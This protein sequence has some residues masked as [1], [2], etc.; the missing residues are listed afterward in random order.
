MS[1]QT[2]PTSPTGPPTSPAPRAPSVSESRRGVAPAPV[3]IAGARPKSQ[4]TAPAATPTQNKP[5]SA[6]WINRRIVNCARKS[7]CRHRQ[8]SRQPNR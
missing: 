4:I 7:R 6:S 2:R 1:S 3:Q 8:G 5:A